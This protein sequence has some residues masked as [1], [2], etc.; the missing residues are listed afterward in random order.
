MNKDS[1]PQITVL[2]ATFNSSKL[3][4]KTLDALVAQTYPRNRMEILA[5]DGGSSDDTISIAMKYGCKIINNPM[6]EPV[7]A[8]MLGIQNAKGKYLMVLD[9]D[10]VLTN[11]NSVKNRIELLEKYSE[12][13]VAFCSGYKRPDDY[14]LLNEYISEFGDPFSLFVYN[15]SKGVVFFEKG[16]RRICRIVDEDAKHLLVSFKETKRI[17]IFELCCLATIV[18]LE[19]FKANCNIGTSSQDMVHMFYIMLS[20]GY[21]EA[22]IT[23]NDPLVHYSADSLKAYY[24]KLKWRIKNNIHFADKGENGFT[25]RQKY[26][27]YSKYKKFLF[28]PYTV[29]IPACLSHGI[30]MAISRNNPVFL[31]HPYFCWYVL[32]NIIIEYWKKMMNKSPDFT[33]YDGKKVIGK[34]RIS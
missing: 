7:N 6:T 4:P 15:F 30:Y 32:F 26:T 10:E 28:I 8:K 20:M 24:P 18:D 19:W 16:L 13:K 22:I 23:K 12:C 34:D 3:L 14:P 2:I 17:P 33:S 29:F 27:G 5:V 11:P 31:L 25:G 9:H 1:M 21:T